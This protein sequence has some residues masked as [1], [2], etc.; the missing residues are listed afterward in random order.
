MREHIDLENGVNRFL[1]LFYKISQ[2]PRESRNEKK[3]ADFL[4]MFAKEN[5]LEYYR[6]K[7]NNV[8]IKKQGNKKNNEP[9]IL[10]A[11]IDMVCVK[12]ENS[13]HNFDT[14]PIEIVKNGDVISAKDT[15]LGAD[16]GIGLAIMLL[17]LESKKIKHPDLECL[18][19]T[20]EETTFNGAENFDYSKL[21][22]KMLI[23]LDHCRD[24]SIVIG[25]DADIC[26]KYIFEGKLIPSNI[27]SYKIK[28]SNVKGGNSGIEIERGNKSAIM[29]L[30]KVLQELQ[31]EYDVQICSISGGKSEIDIST[32]CECII[33]T[34]INDIENKLKEY[35]LEKNIQIQVDKTQMEESFSVED[36][37]KIVD[38][39]IHLKQGIIVAKNNVITSGNI[40]IIETIKNKVI[41]TG[42]LRSIEEKE[43]NKYNMENYL[44]SSSNNFKVEESYQDLAWIPNINSKLKEDYTNIYYKLIGEYP[45][46]EIT[47]GGLECSCFSKRITGLDM[48]SIGSIIE[49]FH[50]VNE[51]M[52][53]SSCEKTI[54]ILL[55][56]LGCENN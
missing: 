29:L 36:S 26:N 9:I 28:I 17:I 2:I 48:I 43:L 50:T 51:K 54:K 25:C 14:D 4:E 56:Y 42:I 38:E 22:G 55:A 31:K 35:F 32:S 1:E 45:N 52:Y 16:Q 6:D 12:C 3:F 37:K 46:F 53:I 24:D 15:S 5:N 7:S 11:H 33:K 27:S 20:E 10:Q 8:L 41:I 49:N 21:N 39:L 13:N 34:R 19:T 40:G 18:F 23:N 47:H 30:A 44:I